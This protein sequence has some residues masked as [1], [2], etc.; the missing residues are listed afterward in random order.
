M[1]YDKFMRWTPDEDI[2]WESNET[3]I[4]DLEAAGLDWSDG[5]V[6]SYRSSRGIGDGSGAWGQMSESERLDV[7]REYDNYWDGLSTTA[8]AELGDDSSWGMDLYRGVTYD[9]DGVWNAKNM[10]HDLVGLKTDNSPGNQID[11]NSYNDSHLWRGITDDI[12]EN[13]KHQWEGKSLF[14]FQKDPYTNAGQIRAGNGVIR[15]WKIDKGSYTEFQEHLETQV[16]EGALPDWKPYNKQYQRNQDARIS[17]WKPWM[18]FTQDEE[19]GE[20]VGLEKSMTS[21][22]VL[23]TIRIQPPAMPQRVQ[24]TSDQSL[25]DE[26]NGIFYTGLENG[27]ERVLSGMTPQPERP[28]KPEALSLDIKPYIPRDRSRD[29]MKIENHPWLGEPEPPNSAANKVEVK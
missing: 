6:H 8:K 22:E 14:E 5:G 11:Y 10:F 19:T 23:N 1:G 4:Q 21:G 2:N 17:R 3:A 9:D 18:D 12:I 15:D 26:D 28:D 7:I 20:W 16:T 24:I 13:P 25:T 29:Y 27:N